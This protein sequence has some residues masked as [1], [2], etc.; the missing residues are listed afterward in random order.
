ME[1]VLVTYDRSYDAME[2][3]ELLVKHGV[4]GA[5]LIPRPRTISASCGIALRVELQSAGKALALLLRAGLIGDVYSSD[6]GKSWQPASVSEL[7]EKE[8]RHGQAGG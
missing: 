3:M 6:D 5:V 8:D 7:L 1:Y 2:A 4:G